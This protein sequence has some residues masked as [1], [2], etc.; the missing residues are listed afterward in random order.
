MFANL[1]SNLYEHFQ[2]HIITPC[3]IWM[4]V[5]VNTLHTGIYCCYSHTHTHTHTHT[6]THTHTRLCSRNVLCLVTVVTCGVP[7]C[8][9]LM[10][11]THPY[12]VLSTR[13]YL[14]IIILLIVRNADQWLNETFESL[15][16]HL[17]TLQFLTHTRL[18]LPAWLS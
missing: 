12:A 6:P 7:V 1:N 2:L 3:Q 9:A 17:L 11:Y 18:G 15:H 5:R 8:M 14:S 4:P 13:H 16:I 10:T